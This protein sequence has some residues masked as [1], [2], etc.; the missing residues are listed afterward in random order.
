MEETIEESIKE[1]DAYNPCRLCPRECGINREKRPGACGEGITLR[2]ARAALHFWEEPCISGR[3]GS[4]T[5]FF[6][7]CNLGCVFCQ[8]RDISQKPAGSGDSRDSG[9]VKQGMTGPKG[10]EISP[11][12]LTE[13]FFSLEAQGAHNINLVTGDHFLPTIRQ[14]VE[15]AKRQGIGIPFLLNTSS[16][17]KVDTLKRM[18]GLIDIYLPDFKYIR[19]REAIR[20]SRAPGYPEAAKAAVAEMVRQQPECIF[21]PDGEILQRGVVVRHLLLP[22]QLIQAKLIVRYLWETYGDR[23]YISLLSQYTPDREVLKDRFPEICRTLTGR[24]YKSLV[25]YAAELGITKGFVQKEG[26]ADESFIP[27]FDGT[28]L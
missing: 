18:E 1:T 26:A 3:G 6:T 8:N 12:R 10:K 14:A 2:L 25:D 20:Y 7:G 4:G 15:E 9:I 11:E 13:I 23:I 22:G 16:Y 28:G 21:S 17:L 19:D 27:L 24:E 5:V